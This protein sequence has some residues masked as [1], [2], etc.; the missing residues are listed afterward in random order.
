MAHLPERVANSPHPGY[1]Q[2]V[3]GIVGIRDPR[4]WIGETLLPHKRYYI[5]DSVQMTR[6]WQCH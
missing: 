3:G 5:I 2:R 6:E 4:G 1:V